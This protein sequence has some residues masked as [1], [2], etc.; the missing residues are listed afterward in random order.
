MPS[1][2]IDTLTAAGH[3]ASYE[4][5]NAPTDNAGCR[6]GRLLAG[7]IAESIHEW[8]GAVDDARLTVS[9]P[10]MAAKS[11]ADTVLVP[12]LFRVKSAGDM[13]QG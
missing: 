5:G 12:V 7:K 13:A 3:G 6:A 8:P 11:A 2:C 1:P 10:V 4:A 9:S